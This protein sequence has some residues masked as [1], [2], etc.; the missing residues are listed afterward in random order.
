MKNIGDKTIVNNDRNL[1]YNP[2]DAFLKRG[3]MQMNQLL[4]VEDD[5]AIILG[6]Q[7]TLEQEGYSVD[8]CR[9][10][11][12]ALAAAHSHLYD[13]FL[14]DVSLPDHDGFWLYDKLK[15]TDTPVLFLTA[16]DEE[17]A[18]VKGL[19]SGA[20]DYVTKPFKTRELLLRIKKILARREPNA[21]LTYRDL[22]VDIDANKVFVRQQE[23]EFTAL[24]YRILFILL[25]NHGRLI[26][27]ER[28]L[29]QIWDSAGNFVNDNTLTVY[30]KRIREK[31]KDA[32]Y[33]KT[34]KGSGY[35]LE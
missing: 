28:L 13:L 29:E 9:N 26:T 15:P 32:N 22:A 31:L 16:H 33:I 2:N 1:K 5:S 4:F 19:E 18:V 25:S 23:I 20:E 27:R 17:E 12:T 24:E 3:G 11:R 35:R 6:L 8:V 10:A 30:I 34:I 7:Y 21:M 14:F